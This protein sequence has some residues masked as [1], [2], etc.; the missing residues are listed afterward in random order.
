M[1]RKLNALFLFLLVVVFISAASTQQQWNTLLGLVLSFAFSFAA[2]SFRRLSLDGMFAAM[3]TG[4][5][6]FGLGGWP[7]TAVVLLFF[8]SS[9][10]ISGRWK[11]SKADMPNEARRDGFQVWANGFW[12]VVCLILAVIFNA[13]IFIIG[14]M[15][16]VATAAAD[17]W[18]TELGSKKDNATYLLT[19]FTTVDPGTDGGVSIK[20]TVAAFGASALIAVTSIYVFSLHFYV[21]LCIFAAGF[22]GSLV[23]SYFGATFQRNNSSVI[24]PVLHSTISIDNNMVNAISTGIGALLAITLSLLVA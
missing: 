15:A 4:T 6:V 9:A 2:F 20:G 8:I 10:A 12:L 18:A 23:D 19:D 13:P 1:D 3:V 11:L 17:T 22:L 16:V 24:L 14:A 7:A 21:F 5:F